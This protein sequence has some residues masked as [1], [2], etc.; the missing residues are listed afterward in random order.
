MSDSPNNPV[1]QQPKRTISKTAHAGILS[2][3]RAMAGVVQ[4]QHQGRRNGK[5]HGRNPGAFGKQGR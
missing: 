1:M 5:H 2:A 4:G 3:L